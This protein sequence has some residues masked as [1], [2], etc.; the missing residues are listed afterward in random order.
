MRAWRRVSGSARRARKVCAERNVVTMIDATARA[1][2]TRGIVVKLPATITASAV[3][4]SANGHGSRV[5]T[6][7]LVAG[8]GRER[9]HGARPRIK[10]AAD[11]SISPAAVVSFPLRA[12]TRSPAANVS[13]ARPSASQSRPGDQR[14]IVNSAATRPTSSTSK[15]GKL[16]VDRS[17]AG[18]RGMIVAVPTAPTARTEAPM[19][20]MTPGGRRGTRSRSSST[21]NATPHG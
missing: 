10:G 13:S 8:S 6:T 15:T 19:S 3:R 17:D 16:T 21:K 20:S 9:S 4:Y 18:S 12:Q 5:G 7:A 14:A 1:R 2:A 11:H